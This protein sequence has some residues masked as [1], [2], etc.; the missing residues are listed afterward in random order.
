MSDAVERW[1]RL[2]RGREIPTEILEAAPE[3]PWGFPTE[4]FRRRAEAATGVEATPTTRRALEALP[5][6]GSVLDV[7]VGAGA[8][9]LPLARRAEVI[10]GVDGQADMLASFR[11]AAAAAGVRCETIEGHWP[12]VA[13]RAPIADVAVSGHV[14]Y[15]VQELEPFVRALE[16]HA[17]ARVVLELTD[18]HPLAWMNGLWRDL[19]GV[20]FPEGPFADDAVEALLDLGLRVHREER[21]DRS[22]RGGGFERREDAVALVR[23]RLCLPAERDDEL[24]TALGDRLRRGPDGLWSA[25]PATQTVVMLWWDT[26][27]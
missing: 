22:D 26:T 18:A 11:R 5:H 6:A 14:L 20:T 27:G 4:L 3:S 9:S 24:L 2:L 10:V 21:R 7:G 16:A 19:H 23:K 13:P 15:N 12:A 17:K 25:G 1:G 8:T